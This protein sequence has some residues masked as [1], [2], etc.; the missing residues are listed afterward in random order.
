MP[1]V[2]TSNPMMDCRFGTIGALIPAPGTTL[3]RESLGLLQHLR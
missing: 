1:T 3:S 2:R